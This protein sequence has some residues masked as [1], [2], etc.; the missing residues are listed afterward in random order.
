MD[1]LF[2]TCLLFFVTWWT[3]LHEVT[4]SEFKI[5]LPEVTLSEFKIRLP[6]VTL[7][8]FKIRFLSRKV[9]RCVTISGSCWYSLFVFLFNRV[10]FNNSSISDYFITGYYWSYLHYSSGWA[11]TGAFASTVLNR[12]ES[13]IWHHD[14]SKHVICLQYLQT[15][16]LCS[17]Q[18]MMY[19]WM[20]AALS[21]ILELG[22]MHIVSV[23]R[24]PSVNAVAHARPQLSLG[25][26][27]M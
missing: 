13:E 11:R 5:R 2:Y 14:Q 23:L 6:E 18:Q 4:L 25:S 27:I 26:F 12:H 22:R 7:S 19:S 3:R 9:V 10:I 24:R 16:A 21:P 1:A 17:K 15:A 20:Q 8:E